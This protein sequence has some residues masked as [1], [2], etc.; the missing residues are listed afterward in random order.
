YRTQKKPLQTLC[1]DKFGVNVAMQAPIGALANIGAAKE[2]T[3]FCKAFV[4][5]ARHA[6]T[7]APAG[8]R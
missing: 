7:P 4:A 5:G 8:R 3:A 1:R 2:D 6:Q